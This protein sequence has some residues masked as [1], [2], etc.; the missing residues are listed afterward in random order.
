MTLSTAV[1]TY[2]DALVELAQADHRLVV[3]TAENRAT[4]RDVPARLDG[5]FIDTGITEQTLVGSAAGL[6]LAGFRPVAHALAAFLT[7]RAFEFCRT[8]IGV[9]GLPVKLVGYV[10]GFLSD[11][12]GPTHQAIEDVALMR[13]IPGMR[14][15]TPCDRAELLQGLPEVLADPHPWYIRYVDDESTLRHTPFSIGRAERLT[16]AGDV[17]I[18]TYG[19][20]VPTAVDATQL[21]LA[22]GLGAT[23]V[24]LR[25]L[26][27]IDRDAIAGALDSGLVVTLEDHFTT[28]GLATI[29]A[30]IALATRRTTRHLSISLDRWFEP[31]RLPDVLVHEGFTAEAIAQ[32]IEQALERQ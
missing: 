16:D 7:M 23:V 18:L 30:E 4:L 5:R 29:T 28:G 14:I 6:A 15:F 11:G 26:A 10:P 19:L 9:S 20:M 13:Q 22:R 8:D 2:G 1:K 12:N 32:R 24:N 25:T 17:T 3:M 31:G 21:L 27:P